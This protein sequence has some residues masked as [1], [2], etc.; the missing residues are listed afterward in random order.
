MLCCR[1]VCHSVKWLWVL[2]TSSGGS[3]GQSVHD[4]ARSAIGDAAND[5]ESCKWSSAGGN[6]G[7]MLVVVGGHFVL[8]PRLRF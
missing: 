8:A 6:E 2:L 5:S 3:L 7:M 1:I 4:C